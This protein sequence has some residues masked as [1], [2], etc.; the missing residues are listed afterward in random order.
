MAKEQLENLAIEKPE[1]VLLY[2]IVTIGNNPMNS[3]ANL[4]DR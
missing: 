3:T 1:D 4:V 2:S